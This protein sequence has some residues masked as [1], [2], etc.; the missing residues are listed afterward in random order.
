MRK[1][2][3]P[4]TSRLLSLESREEILKQLQIME[5]E[6][7]FI[8]IGSPKTDAEKR[9]NEQELL[10]DSCAYFK[11]NGFKT[12]VWLWTFLIPDKVSY[13]PMVAINGEKSQ[14]E[15]CPLDKEFM[16]F[17]KDYI[18]E[19]AQYVKPDM[20]LFDDDFAFGHIDKGIACVC[21][22]HLE[23]MSEILGE[24]IELYRIEKKLFSGKANKYRNAY[25]QVTR[26]TLIGFADSMRETID[27]VNT[28][29]RLGV[30]S[31]MSAWHTDGAD[32][33]EVA[34]HL[35]GNTKPFVRLI[36][37]PYWGVDKSYGN[38]RL[39]DVINLQR[40]EASWRNGDEEILYE[41][42]VFPRPRFATPANFLEAYDMALLAD[43]GAD[44]IL[45][46]VIDFTASKCYETGYIDRHL[47]NKD[48]YEWI[49]TNMRPKV[50]SGVRVYEFRH[51]IKTATLPEEYA[52]HEYIQ[53]RFLSPASKMLSACS[54][55]ITFYG[56]GCC[57]AAF[58]ENVRYLTKEKMKNGLITDAEGAKVLSDMGIDTGIEKWGDTLKPSMEYYC[59][60]RL[61][62]SVRE[63]VAYKTEL[64][65]GVDIQSYFI[66]G[67]ERTP[68]SFMYTNGD[69]YSFLI[70]TFNGY[71]CHE[72]VYR[73]YAR[74]RQLMKNAEKIS[75][76]KLPVKIS[77][78]PDLYIITKQDKNSLSVGLWNLFPDSIYAPKIELGEIYER[79]DAC[80]CGA[81]LKGNI[82]EITDISPYGFA[83]FTVSK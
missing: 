3:V 80:S 78:N 22:L 66:F 50:A 37:A 14:M 57:A 79:I 16:K 8:G 58:G 47:R 9:K 56:E 7:V 29:M 53:H 20:I 48:N 13:Q 67:D 17:Y 21:P 74:S 31:L 64:K 82:V 10:K 28:D 45:K 76:K 2:A 83:A 41:G 71:D 15:K 55:P 40:M 65:K 63:T 30:C 36:G 24:K 6:Y 42:D 62:L 75:G 68:A 43:G 44:G 77:G 49:M 61:H 73:N 70:F 51:S 35:A 5:A 38:N 18:K 26:E 4:V 27:S 46:Y 12:A 23:K 34:R 54:V 1:I 25:M 32:S 81:K 52:G 33:Y 19:I 39:Q 69:G 72:S 59:K 60:E 11:S